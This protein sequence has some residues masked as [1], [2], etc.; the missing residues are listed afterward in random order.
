MNNRIILFL[1]IMVFSFSSCGPDVDV[2]S[3]TNVDPFTI[4]VTAPTTIITV[5]EGDGVT[6]TIEF[7]LS[8]EQIINTVVGVSLTDESTADLDDITLSAT[9]VEI[10]AFA[11]MGSV[12]VAIT[13]DILP[14]API[15]TAF[16]RLGDV[17]LDVAPWSVSTLSTTPFAFY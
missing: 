4:E 7:A 8:E 12:D 6:V 10:D 16:V 17:P 1:T 11:R 15:E 9:E 13:P 2:S 14:D 3:I 5:N